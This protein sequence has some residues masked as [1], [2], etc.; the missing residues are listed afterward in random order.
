MLWQCPACGTPFR[1]DARE[2]GPRIGVIYRCHVCRIELVLN[3][4]TERLEVLPLRDDERFDT[5]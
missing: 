5:E 3:P 2:E 1:F 4:D